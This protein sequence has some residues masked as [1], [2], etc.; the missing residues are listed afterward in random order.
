MVFDENLASRVRLALADEEGISEKKMFGGLAFLLNGKMCCGITKDDLM[1]RV[2]PAGYKDA[3]QKPHVR[4]MD[5]TGKP[6]KGFVYVRPAGC[7]SDKGLA[8]WVQVGLDYVRSLGQ[9]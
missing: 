2:G 9:Q 6:M 8:Q 4:P 5:F 7:K 3:L 1:V